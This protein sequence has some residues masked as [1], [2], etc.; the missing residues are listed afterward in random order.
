MRMDFGICEDCGEVVGCPHCR[1]SLTVHRRLNR[2]I[3]HYC[4]YQTRLPE[5]CPACKSAQ[6]PLYCRIGT[7]DL[8]PYS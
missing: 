3:C 5:R 2:L 1:I 4:D 8:T 6:L 7:H